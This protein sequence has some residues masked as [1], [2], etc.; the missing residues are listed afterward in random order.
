[1]SD[2]SDKPKSA[3]AAVSVLPSEVEAPVV[4]A[5]RNLSEAVRTLASD[6][7]GIGVEDIDAVIN[8]SL[9]LVG[10]YAGADLCTV[11]L[12]KPD[13]SAYD[14][15]H[16]WIAPDSGA[17][18]ASTLPVAEFAW[19][20]GAQQREGVFYC[21]DTMALDD[22]PGESWKAIEA[23][24]TRSFVTVVVDG[25]V[26]VRGFV[27]FASERPSN[28]QQAEE[29]ALL[30]VA[31]L[32]ISNALARKANEQELSRLSEF[33]R[34]IRFIATTLSTGDYIKIDLEIETALHRIADF[35][36]CNRASIYLLRPDRT[37]V[38]C[39]HEWTGAGAV[40]LKSRLQKF[41]FDEDSII[42]QAF[43]DG[44]VFAFENL[45]EL[46]DHMAT[47]LEFFRRVGTISRIQLPLLS[48]ADLIG[49]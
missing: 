5:E 41:R 1:M 17:H 48:G 19:L 16:V 33:E 8:R 37:H 11:Y 32:I 31:G 30:E 28:W 4:P 40:P 34:L 47:D 23:S 21:A 15:S 36:G 7:V 9:E 39:T 20:E 10:R 49:G 2:L 43:F 18:V 38:Q 14:R 24:R 12:L 27:A 35:L 42:A 13:G 25:G 44:R 22:L 45:D 46:P 26:G 3:A 6:F 29:V